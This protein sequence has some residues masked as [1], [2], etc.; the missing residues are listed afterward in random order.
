MALSQT[1]Y[2]RADLGSKEAWSWSVG[3]KY[4]GEKVLPYQTCQ[5]VY[6]DLRS[7]SE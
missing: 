7:C 5:V 2:Q 4:G 6:D 3:S 1:W